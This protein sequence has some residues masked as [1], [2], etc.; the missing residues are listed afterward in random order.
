L[1]GERAHLFEGNDSNDRDDWIPTEIQLDGTGLVFE[2]R[3]IQI[4]K[5]KN[6][7]QGNLVWHLHVKFP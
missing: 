5:N 4:A 1:T 7:Q 3:G 6:K 2:T